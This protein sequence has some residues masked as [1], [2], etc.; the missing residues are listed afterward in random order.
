MAAPHEPCDM[1][2]PNVKALLKLLR[3]LENYPKDDDAVYLRLYGGG[4]FSDTTKHPNT[5]V[6]KWGHSSTAAGGYMIL[7]GTWQEA[8]SKGIVSDFTAESQD[9]LAW[10][11]IGQRHAQEAVCAGRNQLDEAFKLLRSEWTSLPG[12]KQSQVKAD[13]AKTRYETYLLQ[14]QPKPPDGGVAPTQP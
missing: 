13:A 10:W 9:K 8:K 11:R 3:W 6:E 2:N 1:T 5:L 4:A 7:F 14:F 12:A